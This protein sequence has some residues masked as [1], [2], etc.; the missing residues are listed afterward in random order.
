MMKV[1]FTFFIFILSE[2]QLFSQEL[3][4]KAVTVSEILIFPPI[5][6][7]V[8]GSSSVALPNGDYLVAWFQGS[9][10]RTADDVK[11]MGARMVKGS[12]RWSEP[13][14]LADTPGLPDCNPVLFLNNK[15]KLFLVWIV[16]EA[17]RWDYSILKFRTSIDYNNLGA[18]HWNW[19][20]NILLKPDVA[21]ANETESKFKELPKTGAGWSEYAHSYD[22][23]IIEASKDLT[24]RSI[25]WMTRIKPLVQE[26]GRILLPLYSD[27]FNFSL[28]AISNDDGDSWHPSLPIISRGGVQP[29][30]AEKKNGNIVAY[31]RDNGD[32]PGRVQVSESADDGNT[33]TA[34]MEIAIPNAGSSVELLRLKDGRWAFIGNDQEYGRH[35]LS[36]YVSADEGKTWAIKRTLENENIDAGRF[37]YPSLIQSPD[38][39][40]RITYSYQ[41]GKTGESIKYV[42]L[43]PFELK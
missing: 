40:L 14:L 35:K 5:E 32:D 31:M 28:I 38:G 11:I 2:K 21:F 41:L 29:A 6:N 36:I 12:K 4:Q 39:L 23:M 15:G 10:E 37:S 30:L 22:K 24:K 27:G 18:P 8:H 1:I 42:V 17:N 26:N 7:H 9:G 13:F 34:A 3:F 43:D 20:D 19:Q 33:W 16:V 25:G